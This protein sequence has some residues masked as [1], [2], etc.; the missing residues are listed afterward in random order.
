MNKFEVYSE[1]F[2]S[3]LYIVY[4]TTSIK[5]SLHDNVIRLQLTQTWS[6]YEEGRIALTK[7]IYRT[8]SHFIVIYNEKLTIIYG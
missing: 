4:F 7:A 5:F 2:Q 6:L 8:K 1:F 3:D